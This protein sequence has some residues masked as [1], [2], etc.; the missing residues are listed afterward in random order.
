[1]ENEE[2]FLSDVELIRLKEDLAGEFEYMRST[3]QPGY[4]Y[5][6]HPAGEK[7]LKKAALFCKK[8]SIH[9]SI[10][11]LGAMQSI[12]ESRDKFYIPFVGCDRANEGALAAKESNTV[13]TDKILEHQKK[14]LERQVIDMKRPFMDALLDPRLKFYAWFRI[15]ATVKPVPEI[16]QIYLDVARLEMT[17]ELETFLREQNLDVDRIVK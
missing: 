6:R 7:A 8:H 3:V 9:P 4:R 2:I 14:M 13:P 5:H 15:I 11:M 1:M 10:Y 12:G 17:Q 16:I